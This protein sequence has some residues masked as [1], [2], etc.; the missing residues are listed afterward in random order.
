[1][2]NFR[3]FYNV[4]GGEG[5]MLMQFFT[6]RVSRSVSTCNMLLALLHI[7][8]MLLVVRKTDQVAQGPYIIKQVYENGTVLVDK[9]SVEDRV[10]IRRVFPC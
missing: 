7:K 4:R 2:S 5:I 10:H 6:S 1:L 9:G 8:S 3:T